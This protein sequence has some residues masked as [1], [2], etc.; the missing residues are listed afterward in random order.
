MTNRLGS[1][2]LKQNLGAGR[3]GPPSPCQRAC[4]TDTVTCWDGHRTH[5]CHD[6]TSPTQQQMFVNS[7]FAFHFTC[8][9]AGSDPTDP[10]DGRDN[11][12]EEER[13]HPGKLAPYATNFKP[14]D[15]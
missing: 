3:D 14:V 1:R 2:H 15:V 9:L 11:D 4:V 6:V 5:R 13:G 10:G 7:S 8:H 12:Q